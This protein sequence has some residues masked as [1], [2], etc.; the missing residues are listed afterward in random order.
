MNILGISAGFHDA[1]ITL[2]NND[3]IVFA[4]HSER[5]SKKKHDSELNVEILNDCFDRYDTPSRIAYYERP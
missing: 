5:Y 2:I 4:A 1:G 3:E